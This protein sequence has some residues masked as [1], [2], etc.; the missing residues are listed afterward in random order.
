MSKDVG[1]YEFRSA[2]K[3]AECGHWLGLV[4]VISPKQRVDIVLVAHEEDQ[5]KADQ[6][7]REAAEVMV[8]DLKESG[9]LDVTPS[10][11]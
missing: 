11:N 2:V 4:L 5:E 8:A 10:P 9:G 6:K 1:I 3:H 7:A